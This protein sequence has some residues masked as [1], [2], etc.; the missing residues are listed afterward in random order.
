MGSYFRL[1][2]QVAQQNWGKF[3]DILKYKLI[4]SGSILYKVDPHGTSQECSKCHNIDPLSRNDEDYTCTKCG[5]KNDADINAAN[6]ILY[7]GEVKQLRV[8]WL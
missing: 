6:V 4:D 1:N 2:H 8:T 3:F 7:R 5:Y